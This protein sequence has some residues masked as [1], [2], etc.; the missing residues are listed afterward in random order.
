[1]NTQVW[2]PGN[3]DAKPIEKQRPCWYM[4]GKEEVHEERGSRGGK[5]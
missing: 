1:M 2:T 3:S 4:G 5:Q